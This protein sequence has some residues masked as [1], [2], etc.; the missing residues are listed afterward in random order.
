V[1]A[2]HLKMASQSGILCPIQGYSITNDNW[3]GK[4]SP[5]ERR[6]IQNRLNQRAHRHRKRTSAVSFSQGTD[7]DPQDSNDTCCHSSELY[8]SSSPTTSVAVRGL[9]AVHSKGHM[10]APKTGTNAGV[11]T[12][13]QRLCASFSSTMSTLATETF[14]LGSDRAT[15]EAVTYCKFASLALMSPHPDMAF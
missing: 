8:R 14:H 2:A 7:S 3:Q 13:P 6:R 5:H 12:A 4:T 9:P 11:A 15:T 1:T 10:V